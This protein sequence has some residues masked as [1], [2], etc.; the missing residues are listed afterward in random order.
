MWSFSDAT[1]HLTADGKHTFYRVEGQRLGGL[2]LVLTIPVT[3]EGIT[4]HDA[5]ADAM[6]RA[7]AQDDEERSIAGE[8]S[9]EMLRNRVF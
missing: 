1:A 6:R 9:K 7:I 3:G 8:A 5:L 2:L 4:P